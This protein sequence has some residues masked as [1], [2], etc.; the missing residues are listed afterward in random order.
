M[1]N[2]K[3]EEFS[4]IEKLIILYNGSSE[5]LK[6]SFLYDSNNLWILAMS[7]FSIDLSLF[8]LRYLENSSL[9]NVEARYKLGVAYFETKDFDNALA[10]FNEVKTDPDYVEIDFVESRVS[11][12][13]A[14]EAIFVLVEK[15]QSA[16]KKI[17][18]KHLSADCKI[19]LYKASPIFHQIIEEDIDDPRYH[20]AENPEKFTKGLSEYDHL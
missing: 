2:K 1:Q 14:L 8:V 19:L 9:G 18:L 10:L 17:T 12:H 20:L 15:Y 13:S 16:E 5:S 7:R 11:D 6:F 4:E 3:T